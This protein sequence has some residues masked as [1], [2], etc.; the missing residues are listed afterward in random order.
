[1]IEYTK[2]QQRVISR[3]VFKKRHQD[4]L[5]RSKH[6]KYDDPVY[7][8]WLWRHTE[9]ELLVNKAITK[10]LTNEGLFIELSLHWPNLNEDAISKNNLLAG[11]S[12]EY[13]EEWQERLRK[14]AEAGRQEFDPADRAAED[15]AE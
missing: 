2:A 3:L 11:W 12:P 15:A 4:Y 14:Q 6:T 8:D 13:D 10:G 5:E 9:I 7:A 1:M